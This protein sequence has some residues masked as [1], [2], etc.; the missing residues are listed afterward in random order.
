MEKIYKDGEVLEAVDL[1]TSFAEL[2][3]KINNLLTP[4][5]K[6]IALTPNWVSIEGFPAE[7]CKLGNLV[8][9]RGIIR[10]QTGSRQ[11][12]LFVLPEE[13]RPKVPIMLPSNTT[14]DGK[15]ASIRINPDGN[16]DILS[17]CNLNTGFYNIPITGS[18]YTN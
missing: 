1:N 5:W 4:E 12:S 15:I 18:F 17:Y 7:Y 8:V 9:L 11:D 3:A 16:A 10:H 2:E 6:P 13:A 14:S